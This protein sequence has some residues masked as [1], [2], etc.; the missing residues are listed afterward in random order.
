[1]AELPCDHEYEEDVK[2]YIK[3]PSG[4][5]VPLE[6]AIADKNRRKNLSLRRSNAVQPD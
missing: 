4:V 3:L 2:S 1:V 5:I 6:V